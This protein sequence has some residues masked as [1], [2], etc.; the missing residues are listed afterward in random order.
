MWVEEVKCCLRWTYHSLC[1]KKRTFDSVFAKRV[2]TYWE[3]RGTPIYTQMNEIIVG[4]E[5]YTFLERGKP[6]LSKMYSFL[7]ILLTYP[8]VK[9]SNSP[10]FPKF[11]SMLVP[12][13]QIRNHLFPNFFV[14]PWGRG[15]KDSHSWLCKSEFYT[16]SIFFVSK[17]ATILKIFS[18]QLSC[19][20]PF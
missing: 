9:I 13:S 12:F 10:I 2:L 1:Q 19:S 8:S 7:W 15:A 3:N 11:P 17:S 4:I 16:C 20:V 6:H 14:V 18:K 5:N